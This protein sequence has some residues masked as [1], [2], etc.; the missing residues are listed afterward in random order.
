MAK[1]STERSP[2]IA[3]FQTTFEGSS[4]A[5]P[6]STTDVVQLEGEALPQVAV[7]C[8]APAAAPGRRPLFRR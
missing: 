5:A 6:P 1:L 7:S 2:G 3:P 8:A 4:V